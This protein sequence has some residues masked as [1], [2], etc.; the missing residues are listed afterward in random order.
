MRCILAA[1]TLVLV[2]AATQA[3]AE[4]IVAVPI[5]GRMLVTFDSTLP[6]AITSTV[7]VTGLGTAS[8]DVI[9]YRP[10][11]G[12]LYGYSRISNGIYRIDTV[13]GAATLVSTLSNSS[14]SLDTIAMDFNPETGQ[15]RLVGFDAPRQIVRNLRVDVDTG[16]TVEEGNVR[17]A[18]SDT[19]AGRLPFVTGAAYTNNFAGATATTLY[20]V[21]NGP[22]S[23]SVQD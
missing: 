4:P 18:P 23:L 9:D 22:L 15:L 3:R 19:N 12:Q 7:A 10:S 14:L 1:L 2:G 17:F 16:A 8:I 20:V 21:S 5:G 6:G 11:D 13:T